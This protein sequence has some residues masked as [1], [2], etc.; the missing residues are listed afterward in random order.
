MRCDADEDNK[1]DA[2]AEAN[3]AAAIRE[4]HSDKSE[5]ERESEKVKAVIG[6]LLLL[7]E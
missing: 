6:M 4:W 2:N 7:R 3:D 1:P 5:R